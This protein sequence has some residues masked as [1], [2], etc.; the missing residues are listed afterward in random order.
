VENIGSSLNN[1][2]RREKIFSLNAQDA[3]DSLEAALSR[4]IDHYV[5]ATNIGM[6]DHEYQALRLRLPRYLSQPTWMSIPMVLQ[7]LKTAPHQG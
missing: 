5:C 1:I 2:C 4:T 3:L 6:A 7:A